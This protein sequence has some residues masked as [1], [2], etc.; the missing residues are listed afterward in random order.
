MSFPNEI[1]YSILL[2]IPYNSMASCTKICRMFKDTISDRYFWKKKFEQDFPTISYHHP[3][4][5]ALQRYNYQLYLTNI[6]RGSE[7]YIP[8]DD[9]LELALLRKQYSLVKYFLDIGASKSY[10]AFYIAAKTW[11]RK[12]LGLLTAETEL[13][14]EDKGAILTGALYGNHH[15]LFD[16]Y[17]SQLKEKINMEYA[18]YYISTKGSLG[19]IS[20]LLKIVGMYEKLDIVDYDSGL[21]GAVESGNMDLV[22]V[23]LNIGVT[24]INEAAKASILCDRLPILKYFVEHHF[25]Q[26]VIPDLFYTACSSRCEYLDYLLSLAGTLSPLSVY[27]IFCGF[28]QA[29]DLSLSQYIEAKIVLEDNPEP[30]I[31]YEEM[32]ELDKMPTKRAVL[33]LALYNCVRSI[34]PHIIEHYVQ[35]GAKFYYPVL[36]LI[37]EEERIDLME[38]VLH[39]FEKYPDCR[40]TQ[41]D[42]LKALNQGFKSGNKTFFDYILGIYLTDAC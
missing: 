30:Y 8:L 17:V 41:E 19:E 40:P 15:D 28:L 27:N 5:T 35:R 26:L 9:C 11:D 24:N 31:F 12:A 29:G 13:T 36:L 23:Y 7:R 32:E 3:I 2:R 37:I 38:I 6:Q 10:S 4:Y 33:N 16:E 21:I 22:E 20:K 18:F 25:D 1:F 34:N 42:W 39:M 14:D